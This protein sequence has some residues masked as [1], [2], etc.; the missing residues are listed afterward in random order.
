MSMK[1]IELDAEAYEALS[2]EKAPGQTFSDLIKSR[3][4]RRVAAAD[5]K[6]AAIEANVSAETL[7]SID[8][9][10]RARRDSPA[11]GANL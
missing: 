4:G 1:T 2:R 8:E 5:L 11:T 3:F 10:I 9:V 6:R 7:D